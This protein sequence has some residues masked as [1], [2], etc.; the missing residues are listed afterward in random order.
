MALCMVDIDHFKRFNDT[1]GHEAGDAVLVEVARLLRGGVRGSDLVCRFGGEE[2]A[3]VMPET[4]LEATLQRAELLR[5]TCEDV[6]VRHM[7][8]KLEP[9][10]LSVGVALLPTHAGSSEDLIRLADAALYEAKGK[11]RNRVEVTGGRAEA[12]ERSA[13]APAESAA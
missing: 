11:G 9:V 13:A 1:H 2:F 7:G 10:T 5:R 8:R 6:R 4:T 12:P 3:V